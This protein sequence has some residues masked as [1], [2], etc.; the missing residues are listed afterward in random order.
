MSAKQEYEAGPGAW[1]SILFPWF[2]ARLTL[3]EGESSSLDR[4]T[5]IRT[6]GMD[7]NI[8][9]SRKYFLLPTS[10]LTRIPC[11]LFSAF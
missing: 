10:V 11:H 2:P 6:H 9:E 8:I 7:M 5:F 1:T 4:Y 3:P